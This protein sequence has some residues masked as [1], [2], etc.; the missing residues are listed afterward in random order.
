MSHEIQM[1]NDLPLIED[2]RKNSQALAIIDAIIMPE[3][4]FRYFSFNSN[5]NRSRDEMM[6]SMRDGSGN[7]YF[8]LFSKLG[9][10]GKVFNGSILN[11]PSI[12][13]ADIP[14]HFS[15]FKNEVAFNLENASFYFWRSN[16]DDSWS[17]LPH[18]L[19]L[20]PLLGFLTGGAE[21]Y[22]A[23]AECYYNKKI[24]IN[25]IK[26]IFMS[27]NKNT[28]AFSILNPELNRDILEED[29]LE[30]FGS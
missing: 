4:E 29:I 16:A 25:S 15:S 5:W 22:H 13:L 17:V 10:V 28:D 18:D 24:D 30:I 20:L 9:A 1:I 3:W 7:E 27:L 8:I 6:A 19:K 14:D 2:V 12:L 11:N 21:Y 26:N 23:W